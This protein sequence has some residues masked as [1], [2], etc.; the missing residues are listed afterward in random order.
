MSQQI[1]QPNQ[2]I[3][4][5]NQE[6][7]QNLGIS[8]TNSQMSVSQSKNQQVIQP[9]HMQKAGQKYQQPQQMMQSQPQQLLMQNHQHIMHQP[10]YS[11]AQSLNVMQIHQAV[12]Q[13]PINTVTSTQMHIQQ[14]QPEGQSN[15]MRQPQLMSVRPQNIIK[16]IP[17]SQQQMTFSLQ[18]VPIN[19]NYANSM[20]NYYNPSQQQMAPSYKPSM[21]TVETVKKKEDNNTEVVD[22]GTTNNVT[23]PVEIDYKIEQTIDLVKSHLIYAVSKE[24]EVLKEKIVELM[25]KVGQL[26]IE[27]SNLR[28]L[29]PPDMLEQYN[30]EKQ[31]S[32]NGQSTHNQ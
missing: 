16:P 27:N 10:R 28:M 4:Q 13:I 31:K 26:E 29:V 19:T 20:Q 12:M 25:D 32:K 6:L 22:N 21:K 23:N 11:Q 15:M 5:Q 1:L 9:Q 2:S 24:V 8:Q 7:T 30:S 18:H 14:Q 3:P 17:M